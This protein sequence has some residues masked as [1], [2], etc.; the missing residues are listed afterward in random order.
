MAM[1]FSWIG[2]IQSSSSSGIM[3]TAATEPS[4]VVP[5]WW[6]VEE[7]MAEAAEGSSFRW[8]PVA[9]ETSPGTS[10]RDFF[11]V[12]IPAWIHTLTCLH[13]CLGFH[14]L[15]LRR[16]HISVAQGVLEERWGEKTVP[17]GWE[18]TP[19]TGSIWLSVWLD[20]GDLH[21]SSEGADSSAPAF[22]RVAPL[23]PRSLLA[24][25]LSLQGMP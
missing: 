1:Y 2:L 22:H 19:L 18:D 24:I 21:P 10:G 20:E 7:S 11:N 4:L 5:T 8:S 3:A 25:W 9:M 12:L 13:I 16:S 14:V 23:S 15:G 17:V 6:V